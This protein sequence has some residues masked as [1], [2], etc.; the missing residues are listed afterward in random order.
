[1][2]TGLRPWRLSRRWMCLAAPAA[3]AGL[4]L[5]GCGGGG[6]SASPPPPSVTLTNPATGSNVAA[7]SIR[8]LQSAPSITANTPYAMPAATARPFPT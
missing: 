4:L 3:L 2:L 6:S 7:V 5:T 8:Q 1:M